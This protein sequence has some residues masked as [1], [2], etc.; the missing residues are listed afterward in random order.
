MS[1]LHLSRYSFGIPGKVTDENTLLKFYKLD[2]LDATSWHEST[3]NSVM[4]SDRLVQEGDESFDPLGIYQTYDQAFKQ[5]EEREAY[6]NDPSLVFKSPKFDSRKYLSLVHKSTH[7]QDLI[8]GRNYLQGEM[9][10]R[11]KSLR[12]LVKNNFD[13]FVSAKNTVDGKVF[14]GSITFLSDLYQELLS[15]NVKESTGYGTESYEN[16]LNDAFEQAQIVFGP[17]IERTNR[18]EKIRSTLNV[19][20]R[21]KFFFNLPTSM[22]DYIKTSNYDLAVHDYKKGKHLMKSASTGASAGGPLHRLFEKVWIPVQDS[23]LKVQESI[24]SKL[25]NPWIDMD[26]QAKYINYLLQLDCTKDPLIFYLKNQHKWV[27]EFVDRSFTEHIDTLIAQTTLN[28]SVGNAFGKYD[29]EHHKQ[30]EIILLRRAQEI[31]ALLKIQST[32]F[33]QT[34]IDKLPNAFIWKQT[35]AFIKILSELIGKTIPE[36]Y[37]FLNQFKKDELYKKLFPDNKYEAFWLQ[38]TEEIVALLMITI[39]KVFYPDPVALPQKSDRSP[40]FGIIT[41]INEKTL[42]PLPDDS[43]CLLVGHYAS[44][45]IQELSVAFVEIAHINAPKHINKLILQLFSRTRVDFSAFFCDSWIQDSKC[46]FLIDIESKARK[47]KSCQMFYDYQLRSITILKLIIKAS[48]LVLPNLMAEDDPVILES[49]I[50]C[51]IDSTLSFLDGLNFM[52]FFQRKTETKDDLP[53]KLDKLVLALNNVS[54]TKEHSQKIITEF[55]SAVGL[56]KKLNLIQIKS[57]IKILEEKLFDAYILKQIANI[58]ETLQQGILFSDFN[59]ET[60]EKPTNIRPFIYE[61]LMSLVVVHAESSKVSDVLMKRILAKLLELIAQELLICFRNI[62]RL[63]KEGALQATLEVEFIELI[64]QPFSTSKTSD[65]FKIIYSAIHSGQYSKGEPPFQN[66]DPSELKELETL[67]AKAR[68][69]TR[70][71]FACFTYTG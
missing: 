20:E 55:E 3:P 47:S 29:L 68:Y 33:F 32:D 5:Q 1:D 18:T 42:L 46:V 65:L 54:I 60:K 61:I 66:M 25:D 28:N 6:V 17:I 40:H 48:K 36:L 12:V 52:A 41:A 50:P 69:T 23:I 44:M 70:I 8:L 64:L 35:H 9:S 2:S 4:D 14:K 30:E 45:I 31:Q 71:Q 57:A 7:Y 24:F 15:N 67:V 37:K 56:N 13:A 10:E 11:E 63:S 26:L 38:M 21:Y 43:N 53:D 51:L 34:T 59:W 19:V 16:A 22:L 39:S 58:R 27:I 49:G 62:E